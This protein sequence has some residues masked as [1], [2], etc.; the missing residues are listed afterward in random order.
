VQLIK[1]QD[2]LEFTASG[3]DAVALF[4]DLVTANFG[5][6]DDVGKVL[7]S[8]VTTDP[9]MIMGQCAS[10]YFSKM[11][12]SLPMA[13]R[14]AKTSEKL[15]E[16][17][18][19]HGATDREKQ[20]A[21]A[22]RKW[23]AGQ[24]D[25]ATAEW[26]NILLDHPLDGLALRLAHYTHFYSGDGRRMRDSIAR[27]L[28]AWDKSHRNYGYV[29]GCYAFG[30]EESREY[31]KAELVGREA[32]N[33]NAEDAWSV[34]S[35]AH[36][37]EM[38][39]RHDEGIDW[40]N[41]LEKGWSTAGNFR[42]HLH[43]HKCLFLLEQGRTDEI[44]EIYDR[45]IVKDIDVGFY[46]DVCNC[47]SLLRRLELHGVDVGERWQGLLAESKNHLENM[48]L[49]FG[50]LHYLIVVTANGDAGSQATIL[51][52]LR[53]CAEEQTTPGRASSRAGLA[54]A[55][56]ICDAGR[57]EYAPAARRMMDVR[58]HLD[59]IGGSMAQRDLFELIMQDAAIRGGESDLARAL[60]T[61]RIARKPNARWAPEQLAVLA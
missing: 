33:L 25:A 34:H 4:E 2:G 44:L 11:F 21:A 36:V 18:A 19:R 54:I 57:G 16:L 13:V 61:D 5:L 58:Y 14:A 7:K 26:E 22:L 28:P 60:L 12:G 27:V 55:Q 46:L 48:E 35:I 47:A 17:I 42:Y 9:E 50:T 24:I 40:I 43:W 56:S 15:D 31:A 38:Q 20:H 30:L 32:V 51:N 37:L 3:E 10:G 8:V 49:I 39:E 53:A 52:A 59:D 29:L 41:D 23:C 45:Q 1:N 6:R